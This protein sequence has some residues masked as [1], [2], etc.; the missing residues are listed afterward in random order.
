[1]ELRV[2]EDKLNIKK[3]RQLL[4]LVDSGVLV[5]EDKEFIEGIQNTPDVKLGYEQSP[6]KYWTLAEERKLIVLR[7]QGL[8]TKEI[9]RKMQLTKI[10]VRN[11]I[12][13]TKIANKL[14]ELN[15]QKSKAKGPYFSKEMKKYILKAIKRN[16]SFPKLEGFVNGKFKTKFT[17][18]QL[19]ERFGKRR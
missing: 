12:T 3:M 15:V 13:N 19:K 14:K 10:Q 6:R 11:K 8:S 4:E 16:T 17:K 2:N 18:E 7:R 9:A 5:D 1:M